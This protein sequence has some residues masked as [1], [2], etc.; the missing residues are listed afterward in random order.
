MNN[1]LFD[2]IVNPDNIR[3]AYL[4]L[5]E[6]FDLSCKNQYS[7]IDGVSLRDIESDPLPLLEIVHEEMLEFKPLS[8]A[9]CNSIPKKNGTFR[10]IY[11]FSFK[12]RI[13]AQAIYRK[14]LPFFEAVYSKFLHSYRPG[15]SSYYAARSVARRY[16][17]YYKTDFVL[18]VDFTDY[19]NQIDHSILYQKLE[20]FKFDDKTLKLLSLFIKIKFLLN[21][22]FIVRDFGLV[23]GNPITPLMANFYLND[24]DKHIGHKVPFYRRVGDDLILLSGDQEKLE[25][26]RN[27]IF[28]QAEKLKLQ[29]QKQKTIVG[30]AS[31][32]FAYLG[33]CFENGKISL[34]KNYVSKINGF[35]NHQLRFRPMDEAWKLKYLK[36]TLYLNEKN[37]HSYFLQIIRQKPLVND[38]EQIKRLSESFF[39]TLTKFW[40]GKYS[41]RCQRLLKKEIISFPLPSFYKYYLD[42]KNGRKKISDFAIPAEV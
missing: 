1:S 11:T 25:L 34:E 7:G 16:T 10:D 38:D 21:G 18:T 19:S 8:P 24:L 27:H 30:N 28:D 26:C 41:P 4:E 22:K 17:R 13:K 39:R 35:L 6:K 36:K 29:I 37:V 33:Y 40:F 31:I 2:D 42:V 23:P 5:C 14:L 12:D 15:F 9:L 20:I 32:K 3:E